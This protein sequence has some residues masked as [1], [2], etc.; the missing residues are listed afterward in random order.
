MFKEQELV[1]MTHRWCQKSIIICLMK[2]GKKF[3][4]NCKSSYKTKH[5]VTNYFLWKPMSCSR[6]VEA[7]KHGQTHRLNQLHSVAGSWSSFTPVRSSHSNQGLESMQEAVRLSAPALCSTHNR[8]SWR[9]PIG[10]RLLYECANM[11]E[12]T[13]AVHSA[14]QTKCVVSPSAKVQFQNKS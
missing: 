10:S 13:L 4:Q 12:K 5:Y 11:K 1:A 6:I 9:R 8:G 7:V 2:Y 14:G 3:G